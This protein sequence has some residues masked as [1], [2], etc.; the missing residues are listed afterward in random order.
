MTICLLSTMSVS[1]WVFK[2]VLFS[3]YA[4]NAKLHSV[5]W[6]LED[7]CAAREVDVHKIG[8]LYNCCP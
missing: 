5:P 8:P 6:L 2:N 4:D 7:K 1:P 3:V